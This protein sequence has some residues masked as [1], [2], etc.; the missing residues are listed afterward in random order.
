LHELAAQF[1]KYYTEYKVLGEDR[2]I[3]EARLYLVYCVKI[4]LENALSLL[5]IKAPE[6]M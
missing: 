1:H 5:G 6:Q 4:V 2:K 3:S